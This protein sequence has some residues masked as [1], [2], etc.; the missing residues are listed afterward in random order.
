MNKRTRGYYPPINHHKLDVNE[1]SIRYHRVIVVI[2][3]W[4]AWLVWTAL[5][6]VLVLVWVW[7]HIL[8][9]THTYSQT[10]LPS[11]AIVTTVII[12]TTTPLGRQPYHPHTATSQVTLVL[13]VLSI[14]LATIVL[15]DW[16]RTLLPL[17]V[18]GWSP[19]THHHCRRLH[20][21]RL[22]DRHWNRLCLNNIYTLHCLR[23]LVD[24]RTHHYLGMLIK[25][26]VISTPLTEIGM[27][28]ECRRG[29]Y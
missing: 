15:T 20:L 12:I 1:P 14:Y 17:S 26:T 28:R 9:H 29:C 2:P 13:V 11:T 18:E 5:V 3:V 7:V 10:M 25:H 24:P 27:Q 22:L 8:T 6:L 21:H 19:P 4:L 16:P 23:L